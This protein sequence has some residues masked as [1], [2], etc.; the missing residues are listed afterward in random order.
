MKDNRIDRTTLLA[1][2]G[3]LLGL[4][5]I[6]GLLR[7]QAIWSGHDYGESYQSVPDYQNSVQNMIQLIG[8]ALEYGE[9]QCDVQNDAGGSPTSV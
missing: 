5:T 7:E 8:E 9:D 6:A 3:I 4:S 1:Q 2:G